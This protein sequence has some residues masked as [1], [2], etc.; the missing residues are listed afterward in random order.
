MRHGTVPHTPGS[1]ASRPTAVVPYAE[2][3]PESG[4]AWTLV[5]FAGRGLDAAR[6]GDGLADGAVP[7]VW[8]S[9]TGH[10][11][12]IVR[13]GTP[14][15]TAWAAPYRQ[16]SPCAHLAGRLP[17]D[18]H[19]WADPDVPRLSGLAGY[20]DVLVSRLP[21]PLP[22]ARRRGRELLVRHPGALVAAVPCPD[23]GCAAVVVRH[24]GGLLQWRGRRG[25]S[26]SGV[27]AHVVASVAHAWA[28][29]GRRPGS[30]RRVAL[31]TSGE[32]VR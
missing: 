30:L 29:A 1:P 10:G 13:S 23:A 18:V 31:M 16:P 11:P 19:L 8:H 7:V 15:D 32:A 4:A 12:A 22:A 17:C 27:P 2:L 9:D 3:S 14:L 26:R 28:A 21:L 6:W 24:K 20:A 25:D 5:C